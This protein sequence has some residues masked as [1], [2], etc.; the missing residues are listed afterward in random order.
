MVLFG[1]VGQRLRLAVAT[2]RRGVDG[3]VVPQ[4]GRR[5]RWMKVAGNEAQHGGRERGRAEAA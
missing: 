5:Q 3:G 2:T 1:A 4:L